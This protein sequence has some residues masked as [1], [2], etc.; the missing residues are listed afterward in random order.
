MNPI[1]TQNLDFEPR[2]ARPFANE[3]LNQKKY[4]E[5]L[6][7]S[8]ANLM[9]FLSMANGSAIRGS[10]YKFWV[11]KGFNIFVYQI[12]SSLFLKKEIF[13]NYCF[14]TG[15]HERNENALP[16]SR[17]QIHFL[18]SHHWRALHTTTWSQS[19]LELGPKLFEFKFVSIS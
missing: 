5:D 19:R 17:L 2:M 11:K 15:S 1:F 9:F 6:L 7:G 10:R 8:N 13:G 4:P 18:C 16:T 14:V 3:L 12:H